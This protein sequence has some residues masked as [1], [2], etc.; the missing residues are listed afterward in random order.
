MIGGPN[1]NVPLASVG[2]PGGII[3]PGSLYGYT[4]GYFNAT[5]INGTKAYWI[6]TN[7]SGTITISCGNLFAKPENELIISSEMSDDFSRILISDAN[8]NN[9]ILYFNSKLKNNLTIENFSMPPLPP[10]GSFD[11][12]L[13][14]DYRLSESD[15]ATILI[16]AAE[17][18]ISV[19]V[20]NLNFEEDYVIQEIADGIEL[21][22]HCI[23]D[24][25]TIKIDNE[26]VSILKIKKQ[27]A[28]LP[29]SFNLEQNY[30]NPFNPATTIKFSLPEAAN[31][32]LNIFN[33]LGQ[34]VSELVNTNLEAGWYSYQWNANN[35]A[36]GIYIYELRTDKFVS[37]KKMIFLR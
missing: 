29:T 31:V 13:I 22:S 23:K 5:S 1:C 33:V 19:E 20:N 4:G 8:E 36:S 7:A 12:R 6:K 25:V 9:Q 27:Q 34:K 3:I 26:K 2:D 24:G 30:P 16:Q 21:K 10:P 11:A 17:F 15:E 32:T 14:G 28:E 35:N 18:P 37:I